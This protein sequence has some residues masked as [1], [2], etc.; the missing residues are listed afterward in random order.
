MTTL[1]KRI[2]LISSVNFDGTSEF[3]AGFSPPINRAQPRS[4]ARQDPVGRFSFKDLARPGEL[5]VYLKARRWGPAAG[6]LTMRSPKAADLQDLPI[7][8][9]PTPL[10]LDQPLQVLPLTT[11][12]SPIITLGPTDALALAGNM[13][14]VELMFLDSPNGADVASSSGSTPGDVGLNFPFPV[15]LTVWVCVHNKGF[16]PIAQASN[17][18]GQVLAADILHDPGNNFFTVT[19][20]FPTAGSVRCI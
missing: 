3:T 4:V 13:Q 17:A 11:E 8:D 20:F 1:G 12:W 9:V 18:A 14:T 7:G 15:P 10:A 16:R 5:A 6:T 2:A 19:H